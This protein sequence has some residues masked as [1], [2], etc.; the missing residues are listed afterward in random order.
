MEPATGAS[1]QGSDSHGEYVDETVVKYHKVRRGET[2]SS[3]A[4]R[5]GI[6]KSAL[7][8]AN[9]L[10]RKSKVRRGMTLKIVTTTRKYLPKPAP[11]D[12]IQ[13]EP[14]PADSLQPAPAA[15]VPDSA[16]PSAQASEVARAMEQSAAPAKAEKPKAGT[17]SKAKAKPKATTHKVR[18]GDSLYKLAKR[19]GVSVKA[20]KDAN[21]LRDSDIKIGQKLKIPAKK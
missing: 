10:G 20:I 1:V 14:A 7:R 18:S 17:K 11:A 12:S 6:T 19:Y 21:N 15:T 9:G 5:Y 16:A 13:V 3:I 4:R 8:S 2:V